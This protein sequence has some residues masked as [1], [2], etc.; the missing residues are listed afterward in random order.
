MMTPRLPRPLSLH[1]LD[2]PTTHGNLEI[3]KLGKPGMDSRDFKIG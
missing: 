1:Y 3:F 2:Y